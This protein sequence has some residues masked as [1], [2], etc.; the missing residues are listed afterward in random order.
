MV[1][2]P[3]SDGI[4]IKSQSNQYKRRDVF[5]CQQESHR[6]FDG[7]VSVYH[8]LKEKRCYPHGCLSFR[9]R[10][11]RFNKGSSCPRGFRRVGK[12]CFGCRFFV[13]EKIN[14]RPKVVLPTESFESFQRDLREFEGWLEAHRGRE[15]NYSGTVFSVKPRLV[16]DPA[17]NR[18]PVFR[19]FLVV[20]EEGFVNL[21]HL[22]D[23]CYLRVH[24][25]VQERYRFRPG[26]K[27]DFFARFMEDKGRI[28]LTRVNRVEI[29]HRAEGFW[30]NEN[31]AR[32]ALRT[33]SILEEQPE[34]CL[35]CGYGCLADV[36][37]RRAMDTGIHRLLFCL[38]GIRDPWLCPHVKVKREMQGECSARKHV[39]GGERGSAICSHIP[40]DRPVLDR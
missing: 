39:S 4:E 14:L 36:T 2:F 1:R 30:W 8:V 28:I 40:T 9:W 18:R 22:K 15:V 12:L 32:V 35:N 13:D 38:E 20:F 24:G 37:E 31:R 11:A 16:M 23:F 17:R 7:R 21:V 33:G 3:F 19:G 27:L 6:A 25:R 34:K 29:D 26:D 10:C 5:L